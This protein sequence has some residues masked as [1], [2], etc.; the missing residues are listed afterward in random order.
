MVVADPQIPESGKKLFE[1][2]WTT[3]EKYAPSSPV[4]KYVTRLQEEYSKHIRKLPSAYGKA[5]TIEEAERLVK[6]TRPNYV[7]KK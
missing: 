5:F 1:L 4:Y 2:V 6:K 3:G 7:N